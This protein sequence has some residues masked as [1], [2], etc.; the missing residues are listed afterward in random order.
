MPELENESRY[1][2]AKERSSMCSTASWSRYSRVITPN[3]AIGE[4]SSKEVKGKPE[5]AYP[6]GLNAHEV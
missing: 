3:P 2:L 5:N 4:R 6:I 1:R